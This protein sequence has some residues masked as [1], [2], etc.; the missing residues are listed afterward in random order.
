MHILLYSIILYECIYI[1][2]SSAV[3]VIC[4]G[5]EGV[6]VR[7][8][9]FSF[10]DRQCECFLAACRKQAGRSGSLQ[11]AGFQRRTSGLAVQ[12]PRLSFIPQLGFPC[13]YP[14]GVMKG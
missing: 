1:V 7:N 6:D 4:K 2:Q 14:R 12:H 9:K 10:V 11:S 5:D 3:H 8:M 13:P